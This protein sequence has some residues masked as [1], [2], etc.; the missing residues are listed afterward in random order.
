MAKSHKTCMEQAEIIDT[1]GTYLADYPF[2][3]GVLTKHGVVELRIKE[4]GLG[5]MVMLRPIP[6]LLM[7]RLRRRRQL[8][9]VRVFLALFQ[10]SA[11]VV[12]SPLLSLWSSL[13]GLPSS[14]A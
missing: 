3:A 4:S 10:A 5:G 8:Q 13:D 1:F 7:R 14:P 6:S 12:L 11:L 9:V 2:L